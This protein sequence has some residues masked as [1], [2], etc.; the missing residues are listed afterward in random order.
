MERI[1][2]CAI[3]AC[4]AGSAHADIFTDR[5]SYDAAVAAMG[6]TTAWDEDFEGFAL[7]SVAVPTIIGG[8]AAEIV[9][10]G[11]AEIIDPSPIA[12][13]QAYLGVE[14]GIGEIIQGVGGTSLGLSAFGFDYFSELDG[15]YNFSTSTGV[16][17]APMT[18]GGLPLFVGWVGEPGEILEFVDYTPGTSAHILDNMSA[19]VPAPGTAMLFAM[20][21]VAASRR[22]R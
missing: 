10:A 14:G 21:G 13:G 8:G 5:A 11:T 19:A 6:L 18:P 2:L 9:R 7:G 22:R 16:E 12:S 4:V 3:V 15:M 1:T 17:S 20:A